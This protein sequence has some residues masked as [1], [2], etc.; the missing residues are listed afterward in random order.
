[1]QYDIYREKVKRVAGVLGKLYAR[2]AIILIAL[3]ALILTAAVMVMTKG[4]L[5]LESDCPDEMTYGDRFPFRAGFVL[6]KTHYEYSPAGSNSWTE[7]KPVYPGR[8]SVRA[9][10]KSSFGD[11]TYTDTYEITVLPRELHLTITNTSPAYGEMPRVKAEGLAKGDSATCGVILSD[12]G[13]AHTTAYADLSTLRVTDKK[14]NDRLGCYTVSSPERVSVSFK[15]RPLTVTVQN[16]SKVYDDTALSFDGYEITSG[17]LLAGDNLIAVFRDTLVDAGTKTNTPDLRIY[18]ASGTDV[19]ELYN[20]TVKS[21]KLTVEK[22]PLI[23]QAADSSF[24]Y[25]GHPIDHPQYFLDGSTSLVSGH[26]LE[27]KSASTILDVGSAPNVLTFAVRNQRGV[28]ESHNYSIFVKEGTLTVTPRPVT[29]HTESG[30]LVYD[31]TDQSLPVVTVEN[32]V[33][34]EYRAVNAATLRDVGS[35]TNHLRVEFWRDGKNITSNYNIT[36]YTFGTLEITHRPLSVRLDNSEKIY[37]G[38]PLKAGAFTVV[39]SPYTLPK[40][41]TLTLEARGEVTFG[42]APHTY[43]KNSARVTDE[44]GKDVTHN[45][46]ISVTDATLTVNPRPLTVMTH[47]GTKVY[48]G[49]PLRQNI[50]SLSSGSLLYGHELSVTLTDVSITDVGSAVN[51]VERSLTR[52]YD[53][54]TDEDV[55]MYYTVTYAEGTLTVKPRS[56]AVTTPS[57]EWMYDAQEHYGEPAFTITEGDLVAGHT[58]EIASADSVIINVGTTPNRVILR[59]TDGERDVTHNYKINY[60]YG[61]LRVTKRPITVRIGSATLTYDGYAHTVTSVELSPDSPYPLA[62]P[63]HSLRIKDGDVLSF[64]DAGSYINDPV[65]SVYDSRLGLYVT[66]NYAITRYDG[67]ITIEKRPLHIGINGEKIYDG[68]P[69]DESDYHID[70]LNGTSP[71]SGH[72]VTA[73]A[74]TVPMNANAGTRESSIDQST[75]AI[76]DG[77][78]RDVRKNY[79]VTFYKGGF[80]ILRRPISVT[81]ATAEKV[82]DGLPLTDHTMTTTPDS[83]PFLDGH[84]MFMTVTGT[85]TEIGQSKNTCNPKAFAILKNGLDVTQ[86]YELV[87]VTEGTLTVKYPTTVTVTTANAEKPFDGLPLS[88]REYTT[89]IT[90]DPLPE[91][92]GVYVNVT[93]LITRPGSTPN[94][95]T[96][97]IRDEAGNNVTHLFT[98]ELRTGVLTVTSEISDGA[99]FGRVYSD[100][101][102]IVYLRMTSYGDYNGR[103]WTPATPYTGTLSG[104]YSPNLLPAAALGNLGITNTATLRFSGMKVFM[105][106]Y[107]TAL[108]ST[109]PSVGS[110]TDYTNTFREDY[111]VTYYPVGDS[112]TLTEAFNRVP[113]YL[114]PY[115]L[116]THST[117]ERAYRTFVHKEYLTLDEETRAFMEGLIAEQGFDPADSSVIGKVA[118]YVRT[119]ARYNLGYDTALDGED[120]VA[121]AFLR[122]Y[123]EGVCT[124]YA[125]AATLLYRALGI[126]ARYV[127]GFMTDVTAGEWVEITSPGHAWVE[128]YL[129]GLGWIQVEVT[130]SVDAPVDPDLP[131]DPDDPPVIP[132]VTVKPTLTLIPAFTHKTYDGTHLYAKNELVLTPELEALLAL[133]YTY[134]VTV[135]GTR[136]EVGESTAVINR[137]TLRDPAG[138]DVTSEFRLVKES[139]LLVVTPAAV[140]VM[141]YPMVKTYDGRPAVWGDGDYAILTLPD[142]VTLSLTVTVPADGIGIMSLSTLN[143]NADACAVY[144][145]TRNGEDVTAGYAVV[146]TLP[147][148]LEE[149]PVLTVNPRAIELTAASA[150]RVENGDPLTAPTVYL[151]KGSLAAGHTLTAAATGAQTEVGESTNTVSS[152]K[153]LDA[154]GRDVTSL[155]RVTTVEGTLTVLPDPDVA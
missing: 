123:R 155:Y 64:T 112:L 149:T 13:A 45:Y 102:G 118:A 147:E 146:F 36:G 17:T 131:V 138:T 73:R 92:Y 115:L 86:N 117:Q 31:G 52:I 110:D 30:V 136:L 56:I 139:G 34:D 132:P 38:T 46:E 21:G 59:I 103:G 33:G 143:R 150:T 3:V 35:I 129:D 37:D 151:T 72:T 154:D 58:A 90:G 50:W 105:L 128:V 75:L 8:Y 127:T 104:G 122:D 140:E 89:K 6:S 5:V 76:R 114:K 153:I 82:Y 27:V 108:D 137:F 101:N 148:G 96:V 23:I 99:S 42:S 93:G 44:A 66:D 120:N 54:R 18:N 51:S 71:A 47:S 97:T 29:I 78:G 60:A 130:G 69:M 95:A 16:A 43:V 124:H 22:R 62:S 41:H 152:Y 48:D 111:T 106:P 119:A 126:P 7:G 19:T 85:Q 144:T 98:V 109:N 15:P 116:G 121:I 133:G 67:T 28:D 53:T 80:T 142:G 49:T 88:C 4:L 87:S 74:K 70:F 141:L 65:I 1:M 25:A 24:V 113:S 63:R 14:G 94:S 39:P 84:V 55:S 12:Y 107:Y 32:G 125:T 2:R 61:T 145:L 83:L 134:E 9:W 57:G 40:G 68:L 91:G 81:T 135:S 100:R 11:K 77:Y 20:I 26:R 79:T 10:G